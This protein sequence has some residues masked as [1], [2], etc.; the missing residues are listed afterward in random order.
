M[1]MPEVTSNERD[2]YQV[3]VC[4]SCQQLHSVNAAN[5]EVTAA[6][7]LGDLW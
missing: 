1:P 7:E 5:G 3:V 2:A 6:D 4:P